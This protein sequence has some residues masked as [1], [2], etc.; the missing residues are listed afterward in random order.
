MVGAYVVHRL[1][2]DGAANASVQYEI[3]MFKRMYR[4]SGK[5]I[6]GFKPEFPHIRVSNTHKGFFEEPEFR[7]LLET[8]DESPAS[9][10][11]A[12]HECVRSASPKTGTPA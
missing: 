5:I 8:L 1:G 9:P 2:L 10:V 3:A 4:R 6:G 12:G 11:R 7:A